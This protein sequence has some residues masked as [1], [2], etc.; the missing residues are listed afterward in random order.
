MQ[1]IP[2]S[3]NIKPELAALMQGLQLDV[4]H[5]MTPLEIFIDSIEIINMILNG[6]RVIFMI[7]AC[8]HMMQHLEKFE[9]QAHLQ[10]EE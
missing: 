6:Y 8:R 10:G 4:E 2:H 1:W 7:H 5:N 3:T 9:D